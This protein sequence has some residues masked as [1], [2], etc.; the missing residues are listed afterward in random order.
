M[1]FINQ[2]VKTTFLFK[3]DACAAT[4]F[5][6]DNTAENTDKAPAILMIHGW[7]GIQMVLFKEFI[8]R[9]RNA[10]FAVMTFDFPGWGDSSGWPRN[11]I[12]P[13]ERVRVADAA[14]AHLKSDELIDSSK[15]VAW[16]TSFG[17]GHAID[18]AANHPELAAVVAHVPMLNGLD[19][20]K[21]VPL[22]RMLRFSVDIAL[23]IINPLGRKYLPV[24]SP[25]GDYSTMDRDGAQRI[26]DWVDDHMDGKYDNR[27]TAA[28]LL[29]MGW[30][31]PRLNLKNIRIPGL[32]VGALRDTVAPFDE[33]AV[34]RQVGSNFRINT[35]DANHFDPYLPPFVDGNIDAQLEFMKE[36]VES[37]TSN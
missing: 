6:P 3:G 15:I 20:V 21:A 12:N 37:E 27:V 13:W 26:A 25:E 29:T 31:H 36:I 19:A 9:F 4:T 17:G 32:I 28:S 34:R 24:V 23:D 7:G 18:L 11:R 2:G 5:Y 22:T 1:N 10:G 16:G 33:A 35:L 8:Q 14:L 30:Y